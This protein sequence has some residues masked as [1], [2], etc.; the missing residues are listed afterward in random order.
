[1]TN[2][3]LAYNI[4]IGIMEHIYFRDIKLVNFAFRC[5]QMNADLVILLSY[6]LLI[7]LNE[8]MFFFKCTARLFILL[9]FTAVEPS[10]I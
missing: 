9:T 6:F 3:S 2:G 4:C 10:Y 1:M 7:L 5:N 8:C